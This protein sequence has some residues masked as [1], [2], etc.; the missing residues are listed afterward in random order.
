[1]T[2]IYKAMY[3]CKHCG[4]NFYYDKIAPMDDKDTAIQ[5]TY[6][7]LNPHVERPSNIP[8]IPLSIV[9]DCIDKCFMAQRYKTF[10]ACG[11]ADFIGF[12]RIKED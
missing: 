10:F 8:K 9:H 3:K 6:Y 1:M 7:A 11:I 4:R 5:S 2:K 12:D